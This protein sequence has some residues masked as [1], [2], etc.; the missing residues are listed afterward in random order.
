MG[1]DRARMYERWALVGAALVLAF[2][3]RTNLFT[4]MRVE[5][6]SM[7]RTYQGGDMLL[8]TLPDL[9][10]S[11]PRQGDVVI[12]RY[13]GRHGLFVK[14]VAALGGQVVALAD[15]YLYVDGQRAQEAPGVIHDRQRFGPLRV[16]AGHVFV[17]GDNRPDSVDSRSLGP[18]DQRLLVGRVRA[19]LSI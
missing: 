6:H 2:V 8:V 13:P 11:G 7:R 10:L 3:V 19:K 4:L 16:P 14:R 1:T 18:I 9:R 15:G 17:L 12:L 5:G